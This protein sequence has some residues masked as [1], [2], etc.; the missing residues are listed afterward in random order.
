M[1]NLIVLDNDG[2]NTY[3]KASSGDGSS[4]SP[5]VLDRSI[6]LIASGASVDIGAVADAAVTTDTTGSLSGK[7]RGIVKW[8]YE[9]TPASLGQKTKANSLPVVIA[10]DQDAFVLGAGAA[11][12]GVVLTSGPA[13]TI[14]NKTVD[15]SDVS[16]IADLSTAPTSGE[17]IVIDDI[18]ISVGSALT[19]TI[20]EETSGTVL[21]KLYMA[22]NTS[23][24]IKPANPRKLATADKK[25]KIQASG[26]GNVFAHCSWHSIA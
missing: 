17:K 18:F 11:T 14:L 4:G 19:I 13:W 1:A 9:R 25:V 5:F 16:T 23:Q 8:C 20:T 15:S 21:Y 2:T 10:S 24:I 26:A 3:I 6:S 7:L 22:A 12:I